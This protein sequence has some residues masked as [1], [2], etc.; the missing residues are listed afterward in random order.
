MM[1]VIVF[2]FRH[3]LNCLMVLRQISIAL[4]MNMEQA[5]FPLESKKPIQCFLLRDFIKHTNYYTA[6]N[7][8]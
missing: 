4:S 7:V 2:G 8:R 1:S 6:S 3:A 5:G